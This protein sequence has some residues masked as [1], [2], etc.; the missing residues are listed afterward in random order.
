MFLLYKCQ[1]LES[2]NKEFF[3]FPKL[4]AYSHIQHIELTRYR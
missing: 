4:L 1:I 3:Q 2:A